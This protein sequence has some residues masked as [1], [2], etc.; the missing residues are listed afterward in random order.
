MAI[1]LGA[2]VVFTICMVVVGRWLQRKGA[3]RQKGGKDAPR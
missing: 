2:L 1:L 3:D